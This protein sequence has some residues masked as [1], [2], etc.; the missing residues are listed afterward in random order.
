MLTESFI[1]STLNPEKPSNSVI[2]GVHL[3]DF[4]PLPALKSTFKKSSTNTNSLAVSPSHVFAAQ[5]DKAVIHVYSRER[6]NQE[7]V[8][9]FPEKIQSV[10]LAAESEGAGTLILGTEGGRVV[11]WELG[12]GRQVSTP[13]HHLQSTTCLAVD[14]TSNFFLSGSTDSNIHVWSIPGLLSFSASSANDNGHDLPFSPF[15][16]LSNHRAAI[17]AIVFGHSSG[18]KNI[19]VSASKDKTCIVWNYL[20]G[21]ALHTFLL[22]SSPLCLALDPADRAVYAGYE[23]GSVQLID[24]YSQDGLTQPLHNPALQ[25]T[26]TQ[27]RP[28]GRW[29]APHHSASPLLCLQVSYDGTSL[30][31]GHQ[32]GKIH[33]WD[34]AAGKYDKRVAD[35]AAPVTNI[36]MLK[37]IGFPDV[38]KPAVKLHNVVKPRYESFVNGDHGVSDAIIPTKYTFIAQ[39]TSTLP[40]PFSAETTSFHQELHH[41]S[42][43]TALLEE[44]LAELSS[45]QKSFGAATDS[46]EL[47]NL[48]VQNSALASRLE[49]AEERYRS[50]A[51]IVLEQEKEDWR[52]QK[53]EEIKAAR[54]K[55]RRLRSMR[56]AEV[57]RRKEMGEAVEDEDED[58]NE[59]GKDEDEDLSS[60]TDEMTESD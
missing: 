37:P 25:S 23:D 16:S 49:V 31:S 11:L 19:A 33:N 55:R 26:P 52:R 60:S 34:V 54:K 5:E 59:R 3:Y 44:S 28:S 51:A 24:F 40:L 29:S 6:N 18:N 9:P 15:R 22:P 36:I 58:I 57:A 39:F 1:A 38:A 46:S 47:T 41:S 8:V 32:D 50:A 13:Q 10:V 12:T 42:F 56:D 14:P 48:R 7:A 27:P 2:P 45:P 4:Q 17:T 20:N 21:D 30:L 53:D 43:P 35:F